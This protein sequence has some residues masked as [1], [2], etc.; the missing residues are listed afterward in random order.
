M[1]CFLKT[2]FIFR[3]GK[4]GRE[5]E[6]QQGVVDSHAPPTGDLAH[7]PGMCSDWESNQRPFGSQASAQ[8][9]ESHQPGY[10]SQLLLPS[11][12]SSDVSSSR[13]PSLTPKLSQVFMLPMT[14]STPT[15]PILGCHHLGTGLSLPLDSEPQEASARLC[16]QLH[17]AQG[18]SQG[19]NSERVWKNE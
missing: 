10:E 11:C 9:T 16:L 17:P 19:R 14:S 8:S 13:E 12:S 4:G 7:N 18:Q 15:L 6:K 3:E 5:G 1:F 2:L